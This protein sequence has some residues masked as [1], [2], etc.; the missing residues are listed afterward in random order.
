MID[1]K[2]HLEPCLL[3]LAATFSKVLTEEMIDGYLVG[4]QDLHPA[5]LSGAVTVA[6][7]SC[8][9]MPTPA[10]LRDFAGLGA[11]ARK[12]AC[13]DAWEA[14]RQ[15]MRTHGYTHSVDFGP[16]P[17]A[18]VRNMGGW[19]SLCEERVDQLTWARK[20]FEETWE[21]LARVAPES[22]RGDPLRGA[23]HRKPV[24]FPIA[25]ELPAHR[26]L[27]GGSGAVVVRQLAELKS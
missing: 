9:F 6:L 18:I 14:I 4:L 3:Q 24:R 11:S 10:E 16:L 27:A 15:A 19:V 21:L 25:G 22:L 5:Q 17:N 12:R 2:R 26:A 7:R 1:R 13:A 8:R 20:R 23:F